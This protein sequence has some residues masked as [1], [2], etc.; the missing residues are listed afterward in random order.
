MEYSTA[1]FSENSVSFNDA[2]ITAEGATYATTEDAADY[3]RARL[4]KRKE[5]ASIRIVSTKSALSKNLSKILNEVFAYDINGAP[6]EG[7]YLYWHMAGYGLTDDVEKNSDGTY[8]ICLGFLYRSTLEEEKFVTSK[9]KSIINQYNLRSPALNDYQKVRIIYDYI[10]GLITYDYYN[11][12]N[13]PGYEPMYTA[14]GALDS[15][16]AVCQ[17]YATLFYRLSEESGLSARVICGNDENGVPTHGWNIVKIGTLYYNLD[18]TWDDGTTPPTHIYFLKNMADFKGHQRNARHTGSAFD[19]AFPTA[20][21]SYPL[22]EE[23]TVA[24]Q[25]AVSGVAAKQQKNNTVKVSWNAYAGTGSYLVYRKEAGGQYCCIGSTN[26]TSYTDVITP[27]KTYVYRVYSMSGGKEIAKS[28]EVQVKIK[29]RESV[30][31]ASSICGF[32]AI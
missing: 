15:G 6:N 30:N 11:Y 24:A 23:V 26:G 19:K 7:D 29:V 28:G 18:A 4:L 13:N 12:Y 1:Y 10:M 8:T 32:F 22:P 31:A 21:V 2:G 5:T 27:K 9:V 16:Y 3:I 20:A 17:A 14:Y 25:G